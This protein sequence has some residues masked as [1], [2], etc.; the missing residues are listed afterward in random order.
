MRRRE[1]YIR[2]KDE[3]LRRRVGSHRW[4]VRRYRAHLTR[5]GQWR[6]QQAQ[7]LRARE[8]GVL[9]QQL[10]VQS[11]GVATPEDAAVR[12]Q[13]EGEF[14]G[15]GLLVLAQGRGLL[16]RRLVLQMVLS[17][18]FALRRRVFLPFLLFDLN[19]RHTPG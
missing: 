10:L 15:L 8:P 11:S 9:L 14:L 6:E 19:R 13:E 4:L 5:G 16:S 17:A 2:D 12:V 3:R 1:S 7:R 18:F